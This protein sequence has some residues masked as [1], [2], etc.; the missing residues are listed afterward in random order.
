MKQQMKVSTY[1]GEKAWDTIWK[2]MWFTKDLWQDDFRNIR[3]GT[4]G[5]LKSLLPKLQVESILDCSCGL[6][7]KTILLTEMGYEAEGCD[8]CAIA[9]R[10]ARQLAAEE[11]LNIRFFRSRWEELG[12]KSGRAYDCVYNDAFAWILNRRSLEAAARGMYSVLNREGKF[13]FV[14]AHQWSRPSDGK[15][16]IEKQWKD[17]GGYEVLHC[18]E[19]GGVKV[20][21]MV[22]REKTADGICGNRIHVIDDHGKMR[23]EIASVLDLCK[24]T[25]ADYRKILKKV[26]FRR[27]YSVREKGTGPEPYI[28]NVAVK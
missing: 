13:I 20:T 15:R 17:E 3:K 7:W 22:A 27:L 12:R 10:G 8:A 24:W 23:V 4:R 19:A 26:G 5:A 28:I 9:V 14:G 21:T 25:W 18:Y 11:G 1:A 16:I 6:G 2:W